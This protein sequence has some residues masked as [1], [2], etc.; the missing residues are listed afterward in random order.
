MR[1]M[2]HRVQRNNE[3]TLRHI[4][5]RKIENPLKGLVLNIEYHRVGVLTNGFFAD[6]G[7]VFMAMR[8]WVNGVGGIDVISFL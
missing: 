6:E 3:E 2:L 1:H 8:V 4:S 7:L 5:L